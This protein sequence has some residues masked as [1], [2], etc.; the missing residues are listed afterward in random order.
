MSNKWNKQMQ[1]MDIKEGCN[2]GIA[3]K[4][5]H[6]LGSNANNDP[7]R[8]KLF[9]ISK[10]DEIKVNTQ[11]QFELAQPW[12]TKNEVGVIIRQGTGLILNHNKDLSKTA[13]KE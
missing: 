12:E 2:F 11:F 6:I 5:T 3:S 7:G 9:D 13:L 4:T 8:L 1:K 10:V